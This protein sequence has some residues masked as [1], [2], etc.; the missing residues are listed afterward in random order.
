MEG[1]GVGGR[2]EYPWEGKIIDFI[3]GLGMGGD[4]NK[5]IRV[6]M[7]RKNRVEGGH[8]ERERDLELRGI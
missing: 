8:T 3:G 6:R 2:H 5:R 7:G 1:T 4:W